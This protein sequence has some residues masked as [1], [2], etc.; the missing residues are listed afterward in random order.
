MKYRILPAIAL[1]ASAAACSEEPPGHYKIS[2]QE[3]YQK[4]LA[5]DF[6]PFRR[7]R[8]CG[9]LIHI[10]SE[11]DEGKSVTWRVTSSGQEMLNFTANLV[12][13]DATSTKIEIEVSKEIKNGREAYDGTQQYARPAVMQPV[14][15]AIVE[16]IDAILTDRP[17]AWQNVRK[18]TESPS[19]SGTF[20]V[21]TH[22]DICS[23]QRGGLE[24]GRPF[25][26][27]DVEEN[28]MN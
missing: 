22:D 28:L 18:A 17:F 6:L 8:Q 13:V 19:P 14:R 10:N 25:S 3:A 24:E 23:V 15:P 16:Q 7:N 11:G 4:L 12:P 5:A 21:M 1:A 9:I 27:D 20:A 2:A 26:I